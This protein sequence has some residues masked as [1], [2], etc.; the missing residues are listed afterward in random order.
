[1]IAAKLFALAEFGLVDRLLHHR[2]GA[3]I[4]LDRHRIRMPILAAMRE[5]EARRIAEAAGRAMDHLG[6]HRER[7][8]G[9]R[10]DAG[11]QQQFGE[12]LRPA[13]GGGGERAVQAARD[14]I[15]GPD[16]VMIGQ[17]QMR[18][19]RL[20]GRRALGSAVDAGNL[21]HDRV[22]AE[23]AEQVRLARAT[24]RRGDR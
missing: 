8:H 6:H 14:D 12:I 7:A 19:H 16:I 22:G 3:I 15:L 4:D 11:R 18:Q 24:A 9:A 2:D 5:R 17:D 21:A 1:L 13:I 10:A 23:R 20:R